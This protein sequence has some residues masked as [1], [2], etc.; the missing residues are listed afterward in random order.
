MR[1]VQNV[2]RFYVDRL[3][4]AQDLHSRPD[5][6]RPTLVD[7]TVPVTRVI[8]QLAAK[9]E[10][11]KDGEL[12]GVFTVPPQPGVA[13]HGLDP[14]A[15]LRELDPHAALTLVLRP[16]LL[17]DQAPPPALLRDHAAGVALLASA[18]RTPGAAPVPL[19]LA[20]GAAP[21]PLLARLVALLLATDAR[22]RADP[23]AALPAWLWH[24]V[25][26]AT[27]EAEGGATP[28]NMYLLVRCL[29]EA[30]GE[31]ASRF[32]AIVQLQ[33]TARR[34]FLLA[35]ARSQAPAAPRLA[36]LHSD[37]LTCVFRHVGGAAGAKA[38][39]SARLVRWVMG[40]G[41]ALRRRLWSH[42]NQRHTSLAKRD[43]PDVD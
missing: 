28:R 6:V 26:H 42:V 19:A 18:L 32:A 7:E 31:R 34:L 16:I 9:L 10:L 37:L 27:A 29:A 43:R 2:G 15:T 39:E 1:R 11:G 8:G 13:W 33:E 24:A 25:Q 23:A 4:P 41:E 38:D 20:L 12:L 21:A 22:A 5:V 40:N 36:A 17:R 30:S 35:C 14:D 3:A